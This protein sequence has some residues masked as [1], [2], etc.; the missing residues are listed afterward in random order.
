VVRVSIVEIVEEHVR[1]YIYVYVT[2]A[3]TSTHAAFAHAFAHAF[4]IAR[5]AVSMAG[6]HVNVVDVY[7]VVNL[8]RDKEANV[9]LSRP[10]A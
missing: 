4:A 9:S 3:F 2:F 1:I 8:Q 10:P 7:L 6:L 5:V